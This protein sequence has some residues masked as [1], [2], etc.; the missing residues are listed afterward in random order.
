MKD[1]RRKDYFRLH[2]QVCSSIANAKR[3]EI[4]SILREGEQNVSAIATRMRAAPA[5]VSQ[6]LAVLRNNGIL[7][8]RM[9]GT[10][11]FYRIANPKIIEALDI[12]DEVLQAIIERRFRSLNANKNST[13][14]R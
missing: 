10:T 7:E 14:G 11:A 9:Q 1:S 4:L 5:N 3:L 2:A 13:E 6:Q 12:M 8:R